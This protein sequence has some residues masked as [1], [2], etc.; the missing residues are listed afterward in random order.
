MSGN[1][2]PIKFVTRR[3]CCEMSGKLFISAAVVLLVVAVAATAFAGIA[4]AKRIYVSNGYT[5]IQEVFSDPLSNSTTKVV[6]AQPFF[7]DVS[8]NAKV[9]WNASYANL[10][11]YN[12]Q[13]GDVNGDGNADIIYGDSNAYK[14]V[15]IDGS[16]GAKLWQYDVGQ[17]PKFELVDLNNDGAMEVLVLKGQFIVAISGGSELWN[18]SEPEYEYFEYFY[19]PPH[20]YSPYYLDVDGDSVKEIV[21]LGENKTTHNNDIVAIDTNGAF[22][23]KHPTT[24]WGSVELIKHR[25]AELDVNGDNREDVVVSFGYSITYTYLDR[26]DYN[27]TI[28]AVDGVSGTELWTKNYYKENITGYIGYIEIGIV[29]TINDVNGDGKTDLLVDLFR[30]YGNTTVLS[31]ADGDEIY[32]IPA[33]AVTGCLFDYTEDGKYDF[34]TYSNERVELRDVTS[35]NVNWNYLFSGYPEVN[36]MPFSDSVIVFGQN[37]SES[38][39]KVVKLDGSGNEIWSIIEEINTSGHFWGGQLFPV[40]D[41][42]GD[43]VLDFAYFN[44]YPEEQFIE[45]GYSFAIDGATGAKLWNMSD[46][47]ITFIGDFD[48]DNQGDIFYAV[49]SSITF[50]KGFGARGSDKSQIFNVSSSDPIAVVVTKMIGV[51]NDKIGADFNGDGYKDMVFVVNPEKPNSTI[52]IVTLAAV[53]VGSF[54]CGEPKNPY[55]SIMG[56]HRGT[57]KPNHTI[58]AT[59]LYTY[60][61]EGTGGHTEY[62][63]IWNATWEAIAT[64]EGYAGDW[65]NITFDKPVVLLAGETYFYEIRTGSYPQIHHTDALLTANGWINC[66]EFTDANGRVYHDWI[67]AIKLF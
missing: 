29:S 30:L 42:T 34:F 64:W 19:I 18:F 11:T 23:W 58:I 9:L 49:P 4:S 55:P 38:V 51:S 67:P 47:M 20:G 2:R 32:D 14:I 24:F 59:K 3:G 6:I 16:N 7:F 36:V 26:T 35:G 61:C 22:L 44:Y 52:Y 33:E 50:K 48:G 10:S 27:F 28:L 39:V 62:A 21:V 66:T 37:W 56:V 13:V 8:G 45:P 65:R 31:G 15:A 40:G 41:L 63:R 43:A 12:I 25:K 1:K 54:D 5:T 17:W 46:A 60:P 57:I 53:C